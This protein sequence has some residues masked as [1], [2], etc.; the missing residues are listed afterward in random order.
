[1]S[2]PR[3]ALPARSPAIVPPLL[4][5]LAQDAVADVREEATETLERYTD[6]P[7]VLQAL[8]F[9]AQNDADEKVRRF[10]QRALERA[11]RR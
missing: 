8:R 7:V 6:D 11:K 5:A 3:H 9:A 2:P 1:M 10:A 4:Q